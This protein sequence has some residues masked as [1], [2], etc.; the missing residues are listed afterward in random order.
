MNTATGKQSGRGLPP[1]AGQRFPALRG[2]ARLRLLTGPWALPT[3]GPVRAAGH[4][5]ATGVSETPPGCDA[6]LDRASC[7]GARAAVTLLSWR[8]SEVS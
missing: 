3:V 6:A 4:V 5:T 7:S 1:A 8:V 2:Q